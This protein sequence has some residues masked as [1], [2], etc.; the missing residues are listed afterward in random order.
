MA[1]K[2]VSNELGIIWKKRP[3]QNPSIIAALAGE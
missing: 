3:C 2:L 1:E